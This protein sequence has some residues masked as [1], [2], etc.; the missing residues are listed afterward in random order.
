MIIILNFFFTILIFLNV[1]GYGH[2]LNYRSNTSKSLILYY[3]NGSLILIF[4]SLIINFLF[5]LNNF[6]TNFFFIIG[7]FFGINFI[8]KEKNKDYY[9]NILLISIIVSII[10][11]KSASYNDYEL[12]HL[13]YTE[14]LRKF[15]IIFGL[16]NFDP[17]YGHTSIFQNI[18]AIQY[19]FVMNYDSYIYYTGIS[20]F[21]SLKFLLEKFFKTQNATIFFLTITS[22]IYFLLHGNRYGSLGNDMPAHMFSI[23]CYVSFILI[24][25]VNNFNLENENF[26]IFISTLIIS[27]LAKITLSLN[28]L[29]ILPILIYKKKLFYKN[30]KLTIFCLVIGFLFLSKNFVNT[31]CFIYPVS[32]T[33]L[34]TSWSTNKYDFS[35]PEYTEK[36]GSVMVKEFM[37][38]DFIHNNNLNEKKLKILIKKEKKLYET[39]SDQQKKYFYFFHLY[40]SYDNIKIW[41]KPYLKN[42]FK[43]KILG[44]V[45][46]ILFLNFAILVLVKFYL[47]T[48][49]SK[50]KINLIE[51]FLFSVLVISLMFWFFKSPILRYGLSYVLILLNYPSLL[52][53]KRYFGDRSFRDK[54]KKIFFIIFSLFFIFLISKNLLRIYFYQESDY[55]SKNIVP[56]KNSQHK[57]IKKKDFEYK[58][59]INAT[60]GKTEPLCTVFSN[61]FNKS[62]FYMVD[63]NRYIIFKKN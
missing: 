2:L 9:L 29:L 52:I 61:E 43:R 36:M 46:S 39:L 16:S 19:N 51:V 42:H 4:F 63:E 14:I 56:I 40:N 38:T 55:Y 60:C 33:C 35:S 12:Y 59:P 6:I 32:F 5:P 25:L 17:R 24:F 15:K 57:L 44:E 21:L 20:V 28:A 3:L 31:S 11:F 27:S 13:P 54:C 1:L 50:E 58:Q 49:K 30:Y 62:D 37:N 41:I 23:L 7:I 45:L 22:I 8:V 53:L 10:T 47:K 18:V 48:S 34:K 26:K